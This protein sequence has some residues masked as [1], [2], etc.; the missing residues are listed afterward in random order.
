[1]ILGKDLHS[2]RK[3]LRQLDRDVNVIR[4]VEV[5]D[6][7]GDLQPEIVTLINADVA[8]ISRL[9]PSIPRPWQFPSAARLV[10]A[11]S[12]IRL[13]SRAQ[14]VAGQFIGTLHDQ[15]VVADQLVDGGNV[16][17]HFIDFDANSIQP[18]RKST[19]STPD[20]GSAMTLKLKAG[21]FNW[22]SPTEQ[23]AWMSSTCRSWDSPVGPDS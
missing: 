1:M 14:V 2:G 20:T 10:W 9:I 22:G 4:D 17:V 11:S 16:E 12:R 19:W 3:P 6:F 23:V 8:L 7:N 5:G 18:V 15:L 13:L 21:R